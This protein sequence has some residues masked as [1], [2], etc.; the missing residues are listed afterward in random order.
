MK[1]R[2]TSRSMWRI[3]SLQKNIAPFSTQQAMSSAPAK[4]CEI[5]RPIAATRSSICA[6]LINVV[7]AIFGRILTS[8]HAHVGRR[9][10]FA[11]WA[12]RSPHRQIQSDLDAPPVRLRGLQDLPPAAA[13]VQR[14]LSENLRAHQAGHTAHRSPPRRFL[15]ENKG[16]GE[17]TFFHL[18]IKFYLYAGAVEGD[19]RDKVDFLFTRIGEDYVAERGEYWS[20]ASLEF[21]E[22]VIAL[23]SA[24]RLPDAPQE[25]VV[26]VIRQ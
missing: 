4:S 3:R 26:R 6:L 20:R 11:A 16:P 7:C 1:S 25:K 24:M 10:R 2:A 15:C 14:R 23:V 5:C 18:L 21:R 19:R 12:L 17:E 8:S 9:N 22:T 13:S